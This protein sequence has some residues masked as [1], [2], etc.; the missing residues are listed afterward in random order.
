MAQNLSLHSMSVTR[1]LK[2]RLAQDGQSIRR[3]EPCLPRPAKKPPAGLDWIHEIKHDGFRIIAHREAGRVRL[4]TRNGFDLAK[5]FPFATAAI[6]ALPV[7]S[8]VVDAEAIA[9]DENGL[10]VF[11]LIRHRR[12]GHPVTLCGFDLLELD[13]V[14]L[15]PRP[16]EERKRALAKLLRRP[17]PGIALNEHYEEDGTII[18]KHA[19]ML[20]CEGIVSKRRGSPYRSGRSDNWIKVKN[21][22]APAVRRLEEEEWK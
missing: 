13:G 20:G 11:D 8:C 1:E 15:R 16:I 4:I 6:A 21:P 19:C 17:H 12:H 18:F 9:C 10:A 5:R 22:D 3:F 7:A 2:R 14:D